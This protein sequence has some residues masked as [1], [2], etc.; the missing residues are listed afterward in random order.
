[1]K[2]VVIILIVV[3]AIVV[4]LTAINDAYNSID[5]DL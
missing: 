3:V 5:F 1:M 4:Y 2:I